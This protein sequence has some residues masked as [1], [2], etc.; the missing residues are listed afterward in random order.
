MKTV[1][2]HKS[3]RFPIAKQ[4]TALQTYILSYI[5]RYKIMKFNQINKNRLLQ[6]TEIIVFLKIDN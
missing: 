5:N 3:I 2:L 6:Q 1:F 4:Q